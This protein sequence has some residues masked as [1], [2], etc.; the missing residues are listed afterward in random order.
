M[1]YTNTTGDYLRVFTWTPILFLVIQS[2]CLLYFTTH[3]IAIITFTEKSRAIL[4]PKLGVIA[5]Q[6]NL[7][8][9]SESHPLA[10]LRCAS[11][12]TFFFFGKGF[13]I[14]STVYTELKDSDVLLDD[15]DVRE[16]IAFLY[17]D[18]A[19]PLAELFWW[20]ELKLADM[21]SFEGSVTNGFLLQ[22]KEGLTESIFL[23]YHSTTTLVWILHRSRLRGQAWL[24]IL[25]FLTG[26]FCISLISPA[27]LELL[28]FN[29][30]LI[31][32]TL[33][34][35]LEFLWCWFS[36]SSGLH[37][38]SSNLLWGRTW[39][40]KCW[41]LSLMRLP[42]LCTK[43]RHSVRRSRFGGMTCQWLGNRSLSASRSWKQM[44]SG[45]EKVI[46]HSWT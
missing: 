41:K 7:S 45:S 28:G 29:I 39:G 30:Q 24:D 21:G 10:E 19:F 38:Y 23:P 40:M 26:L 35:L 17:I 44:V 4:L 43:G 32:T 33:F 15:S 8:L 11:S 6:P 31:V 9:T 34:P 13:S 25:S 18:I 22:E 3:F 2:F 16:G 36:E 37:Y 12:T 42:L 14:T 27:T 20:R 1:K 5:P 46:T